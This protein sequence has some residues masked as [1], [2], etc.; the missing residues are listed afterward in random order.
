MY[1]Y[2]YTY[3]CIYICIYNLSQ[4]LSPVTVP[5]SWKIYR[6]ADF[7]DFVLVPARMQAF[8]LL[9]VGGDLQVLRGANDEAASAPAQGPTNT[10]KAVELFASPGE[11]QGV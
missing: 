8:H 5:V 3:I 7:S 2:M 11:S 4:A 10:H 9:Q 6:G 1:I